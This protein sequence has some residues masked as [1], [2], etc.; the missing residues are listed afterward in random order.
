[1]PGSK[2]ATYNS[3]S[4]SHKCGVYLQI[5]QGVGKS[6]CLFMAA[7]VAW[8]CEWVVLYIPRGDVWSELRSERAC[9]KYVLDQLRVFNMDILEKYHEDVDNELEMSSTS[10]GTFRIMSRLQKLLGRS[11]HDPHAH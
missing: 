6:S 7:A 10:D 9:A 4:E 2:A 11:N 1:M 8:A 3:D 5:P